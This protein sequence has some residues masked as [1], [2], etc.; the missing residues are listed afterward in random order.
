MTHERAETSDRQGTSRRTFL[1]AYAAGGFVSVMHRPWS[2]QETQPAANECKYL[3]RVRSETFQGSGAQVRDRPPLRGTCIEALPDLSGELTIYLGGGEGGIYMNLMSLFEDIYP[4]FSPRIRLAPSPQLANTIIE[5]TRGGASPADVFW[6]V[7]AGSLGVVAKAGATSTLPKEVV[8]TVPKTFHPNDQWVGIAGRARSIPYNTEQFSD[9]DIPTDIFAFP[10]EERFSGVM[11][12]APTYEAF[13]AFVTAMRVLN[14]EQKTKQWLRGM[15]D[16]EPT[17]YPDEFLVSNAVA[18]GEIDAGFA[19]HY[20][21]LR[22]KTARPKA[23][24]EL[25][26]TNNDAGALI[27]VAGVEVIQ[28]TKKK[29]LAVAFIRHLLSVEAQEY[30]ATRAF[31]YPMIPGVPPVGDL[32]RIN[33]LNP[34]NIDLAKLA[35]LQ[36]TLAL[37]REVGVL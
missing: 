9:A 24:I 28:G 34:P 26:F 30:F 1:Q 37:M 23:P 21:A 22:V 15:L 16:Q 36:P 29:A 6:A 20:Y 8:N 12:W 3:N 13:Q 31:D 4:E 19:N 7:D 35:D 14:G 33:E 11:G 25:A 5:E 18:D 32:P 2:V 27:N 17:E 10:R